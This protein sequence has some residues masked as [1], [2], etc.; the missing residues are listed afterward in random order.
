MVSRYI[1][2][3]SFKVAGMKRIA[4]D[5]QLQYFW[6][7]K[8]NSLP[9]YINLRNRFDFV[10]YETVLEEYGGDTHNGRQKYKR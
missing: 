2:L 5:K 3:N 7:Y 6:S 10:E 8:W 9:G 1:H 4:A